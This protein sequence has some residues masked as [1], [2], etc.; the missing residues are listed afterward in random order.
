MQRYGSSCKRIIFCV[1]KWGGWD[2]LRAFEPILE[3]KVACSQVQ[4]GPGREGQKH[5]CKGR[6]VQE[7]ASESF[8]SI[9][10]RTHQEEQEEL[11]LTWCRI[12]SPV[13]LAA[14]HT[15]S[16]TGKFLCSDI[17][18][19]LEDVW[20]DVWPPRSQV[21]NWLLGAPHMECLLMPLRAQY[22][23]GE[24]P[25]T[26]DGAHRR[27]PA[28]QILQMSKLRQRETVLCTFLWAVRIWIQV[29]LTAK[30]VLSNRIGHIIIV[31]GLMFHLTTSTFSLIIV[32]SISAANLGSWRQIPE[33]WKMLL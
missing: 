6:E 28:Q 2:A 25:V 4:S 26:S 27:C 5:R 30:L 22:S 23:V 14:L 7:I 15:P 21:V 19:V 31:A 17:R 1:W 12:R 32:A 9:S 33:F 11:K 20:T 16:S 3:Q 13:K 29:H 24:G 18:A 8:G 10:M